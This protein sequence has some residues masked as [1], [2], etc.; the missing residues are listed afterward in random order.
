EGFDVLA[1][2]DATKVAAFANEERG[3]YGVQWHPEVKHSDHGQ[4]VLENFLHKGAGLASDWNSGNV[5]AEQIE[6]IREQVGDARVISALSGG[7]DSAVSTALVHKA[8][9]DQLTAV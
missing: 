1:T 3:F 2:T 8:I 4:Q 6:R 9:G 5:I 7:V